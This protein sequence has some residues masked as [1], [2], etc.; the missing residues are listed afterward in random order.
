MHKLT[1]TVAGHPSYTRKLQR[2]VSVNVWID[3]IQ[4]SGARG[5]I[6]HALR[7]VHERTR[8]FHVILN[9]DETVVSTDYTLAGV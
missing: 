1:S 2:G 9:K 3:D 5:H 4:A 7:R 8:R 6:E